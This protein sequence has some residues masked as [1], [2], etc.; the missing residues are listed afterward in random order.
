VHTSGD[1]GRDAIREAQPVLGQSIDAA[2][3]LRANAM[4]KLVLVAIRIVDGL[5]QGRERP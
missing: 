3:V 1:Q 2:T 4:R 5:R